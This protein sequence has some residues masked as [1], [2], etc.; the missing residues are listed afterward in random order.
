MS[1]FGVKEVHF[2]P[3]SLYN[4]RTFRQYKTDKQHKI[5]TIYILWPTSKFIWSNLFDLI[6][7]I[8]QIIDSAG[9]EMIYHVIY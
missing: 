4:I 7:N 8:L 3:F 9:L 5:E 6:D 1:G 2:T